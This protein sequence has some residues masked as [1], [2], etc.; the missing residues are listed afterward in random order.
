MILRS[1]LL[2]LILGLKFLTPWTAAPEQVIARGPQSVAKPASVGLYSFVTGTDGCPREIEW[3]AECGGFVL[4]STDGHDIQ[5]FCKVN[6]GVQVEKFPAEHGTK[7]VFTE[8][9]RQD[10]VVRRKAITVLATKT[11]SVT[12]EEEDTVIFD[13]T[14]KF[15]WEHSKNQ[16]GFSCLYSR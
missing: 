9:L 6:K 16:K 11:D 4:S 8:I 2:F 15:L 12:F 14:G 10:N 13:E 7:K 5:K 3:S 1:L